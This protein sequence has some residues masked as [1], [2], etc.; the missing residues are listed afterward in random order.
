MLMIFEH[1]LSFLNIATGKSED[2]GV[3]IFT[4]AI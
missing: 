1:K 3:F 4:E 2:Q